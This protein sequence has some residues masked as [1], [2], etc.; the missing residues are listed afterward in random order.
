MAVA[1]Q[2][3]VDALDLATDGLVD[4]RLGVADQ[5][6]HVDLAELLDPLA[7]CGEGLA[8]ELAAF[9]RH[10]D[11]ADDPDEPTAA[12]YGACQRPGHLTARHVAREHGDVVGRRQA[13]ELLD[14]EGEIPLSRHERVDAVVCERL[15]LELRLQRALGRVRRGDGSGLPEQVAAVDDD[16]G[17]PGALLDEMV[18]SGQT[19]QR[20]LRSATGLDLAIHVGGVDERDVVGGGLGGSLGTGEQE[21]DHMPSSEGSFSS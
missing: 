18:A 7:R 4:G 19:A 20:I 1:V 8:R 6:H 21:P 3:E 11:H 2:D 9:S 16:A 13:L 5:H 14:A 15:G 17:L 10:A 12:E